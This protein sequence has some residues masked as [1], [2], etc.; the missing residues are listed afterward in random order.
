VVHPRRAAPAG[1]DLKRCLL[2]P[3]LAGP[4]GVAAVLA[5][6]AILARADAILCRKWARAL[7]ARAVRPVW[8]FEPTSTVPVSYDP[9]MPPRGPKYEVRILMLGR[10]KFRW[11]VIARSGSILR[12]GPS[13]SV[14]AA[15]EANKNAL[16]VI[17]NQPRPLA[18]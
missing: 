1:F 16:A 8:Y 14:S 2:L 3:P 17:R 10:N 18:N 15:R 7:V 11:E 12:A 13:T 6:R 5:S 4:L 9:R